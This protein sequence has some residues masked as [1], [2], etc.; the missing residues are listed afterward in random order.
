MALLI[1]SRT[2]LS[3]SGPIG[4][5]NGFIRRWVARQATPT[6]R[7]FSLYVLKIRVNV[8]FLPNSAFHGPRREVLTGSLS[9]TGNGRICVQRR[10]Y[11]SSA[12]MVADAPCEC[13]TLTMSNHLWGTAPANAAASHSLF[14]YESSR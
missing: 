5:L 9:G 10:L 8:R 11:I 7:S 14:Q 13:I 1:A 6:T 12:E 4:P 3:A 2:Y